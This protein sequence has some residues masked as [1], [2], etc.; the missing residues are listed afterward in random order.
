MKNIRG[1][2]SVITSY[3][4]FEIDDYIHDMVIKE[5]YRPVNEVVGLMK[6]VINGR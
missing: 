4:F 2:I 5:I 1:R 3:L 6:G